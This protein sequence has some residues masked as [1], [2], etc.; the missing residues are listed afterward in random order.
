MYEPQHFKIEDREELFA[1]IR[2][3]SL[4]VLIS[5]GDERL[6]ANPVPFV[7][8]K[9]VDGRD[10]LRAHLA[11]PN[12]QW[13]TLVNGAEALVVFQGVGH[14]V[15]PSWYATKREHGK[16]VPTWNYVHVQVRGR[17]SVHDNTD[18]LVGQIKA[19]TDQH[20]GPRAE[21]WAV[22][23]APEPF[24]TAQM[25]GIVGIEIAIDEIS[26][27]FKL[28]QNRSQ[29]DFSGVAEGLSSEA[30]A[31]GPVMAALMR[32]KFGQQEP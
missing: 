6:Q 12:P 27:K 10:V 21:P 20:E 5:S 3:H 15:T 2:E 17:A 11:R 32:G 30:D 23:D 22:S 4:G 13:R 16:V 29:A 26:G 24:I 14:Y 19:L 18:F 8:A 25:R 31:V 1:V 7:L 28:S 9:D